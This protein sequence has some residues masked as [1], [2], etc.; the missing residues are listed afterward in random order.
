MLLI[1]IALASPQADT[2]PST[3]MT[4]DSGAFKTFPV[5]SRRFPG[6]VMIRRRP[7]QRSLTGEGNT[8]RRAGGYGSDNF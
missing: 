4:E 7:L 5:V 6:F 8:V 2:G 1:I 3:D